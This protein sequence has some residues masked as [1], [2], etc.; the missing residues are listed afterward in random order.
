MV[1]DEAQ[2]RK[3]VRRIATAGEVGK[4]LA[5]RHSHRQAR[6]GHTA[7]ENRGRIEHLHQAQA[8]C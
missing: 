4:A 3:R 5:V 6:T 8:R 2:G 1:V 7:Q